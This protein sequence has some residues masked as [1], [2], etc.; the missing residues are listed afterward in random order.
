MGKEASAKYVVRLSEVECQSLEQL[1]KSPRVA[2]DRALRARI[3]LKADADGPA[4]TDQALAVA[5]QVSVSTVQ[6][7]RRRFVEEGFEAAL[8]RRPAIRTKPRKLDGAQEAHLVAL[9]CSPPPQGSVRWTMRLL[10][11]Q[12]VELEI[13]DTISDETVRKTLKKT[14]SSPGCRNNGSFPRKPTPSSSAR[15][16]TP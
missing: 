9:T 11:D 14:N 4:W 2:R 1:I 7:L 10:A 13:V 12:L 3:L 6:R 16:K 15:W 8:A 5:F